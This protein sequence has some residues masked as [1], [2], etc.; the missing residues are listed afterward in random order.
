MKGDI[1]VVDDDPGAIL[2][3]RRILAHVAPIRF[4][5]NGCDALRL[6][7]ERAPDL[8]LLDAEMPGLSGF[9]VC[10]AMKAD[11]SLA[12]VPVIFAH[13]RARQRQRRHLVLRQA[14][15]VVARGRLRFAFRPR[16]A[17]QQRHRCKSGAGR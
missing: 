13:W 14:Q 1:L 7:R 12:Q 8:M 17:Q 5:T 16:P 15:P 6:A 9:E 4:A 2:L 11:P 10:E 3:M